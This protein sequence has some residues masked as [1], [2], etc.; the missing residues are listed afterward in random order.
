MPV[1]PLDHPDPLE[2]LEQLL[3]AERA[4][5]PVPEKAHDLREESAR[6]SGVCRSGVSHELA[7]DVSVRR[8]VAPAWEAL[9]ELLQRWS[10]AA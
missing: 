5:A 2:P 10:P 1:G 4:M 7:R 8:Q 6:P 9:P 3:P